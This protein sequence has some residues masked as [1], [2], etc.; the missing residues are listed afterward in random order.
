MIGLFKC[1][2]VRC[3]KRAKVRIYLR[4]HKRPLYACPEHAIIIVQ[5]DNNPE[6]IIDCPH[7]GSVFGWS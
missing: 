7:C 6:Y 5:K 1:S 4:G 2:H 3:D